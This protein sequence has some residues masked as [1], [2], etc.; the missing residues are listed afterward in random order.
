MCLTFYN[1]KQLRP[2][3]LITILIIYISNTTFAQDDKQPKTSF[4][5]YLKYMQSFDVTHGLDSVLDNHLIHNRLN[6]SWLPNDNWVFR[7]EMRNRM[8]YGDYV[9]DILFFKQL[10]DVNNDQLNL[11]AWVLDGNS[12]KIL[13][14]ID[15]AY[16]RYTHKKLEVTVGRQRINWGINTV[17]NPNDIF[18]A[19]SFFDFDYEERPGSDAISITYHYNFASKIEI[20]SKFSNNIEDYTGALLWKINQ[21]GYDVQLIAGLM[22]NNVVVGTG[23]AGSI[24]SLG[25]KGEVSYFS[26]LAVRE[27][28]AFVGSI[29]ADY[30]FDEGSYMLLSYFYNSDGV[31][32]VDLSRLALISSGRPLNAKNLLPFKSAI[33]F[34]ISEPFS[35]LVSGNLSMMYFPGSNSSFIGPGLAVSAS[36]N[37]NF[38]LLSQIFTIEGDKLFNPI[39]FQ[40]YLRAKWSF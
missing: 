16:V 33:F 12:V 19:Y 13:S 1:M 34:Q 22:E 30:V 11:S 14:E 21:S 6:F 23:W 38:D 31:D 40:V 28:D 35:P 39:S 4:G 15:R 10:V 20:A 26:A 8:F 27:S 25:F 37:L 36:N 7:A 24:K 3:H 32:E 17:W 9:K 29:S 18:N 2:R 5:G